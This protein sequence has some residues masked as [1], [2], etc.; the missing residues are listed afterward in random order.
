MQFPGTSAGAAPTSM[1]V[2]E[3]SE[4]QNLATKRKILK[5][6]FPKKTDDLFI[7]NNN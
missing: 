3:P 6:F 5:D 2:F 4:V 7:L 1:A